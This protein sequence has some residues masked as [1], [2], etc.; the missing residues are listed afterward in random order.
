MIVLVSNSSS[1]NSY[2]NNNSGIVFL[3]RRWWYSSS[4]DGKVICFFFFFQVKIMRLIYTCSF[5][6][7]RFSLH[8][9]FLLYSSSLR[10]SHFSHSHSHFFPLSIS[11]YLSFVRF[12]LLARAARI[13][14]NDTAIAR[15]R[16]WRSKNPSFFFSF[17]F[18]RAKSF[19]G[20]VCVCF[21]RYFKRFW[22][23]GSMDRDEAAS[24]EESRILFLR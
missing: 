4:S 24:V 19:A 15:I 3:S 11:F 2:S 1:R 14:N 17:L 22:T 9:C 8:Y 13:R 23:E 7:F 20:C 5:P 18:S 6:F 16:R 12:R 10:S 21:L